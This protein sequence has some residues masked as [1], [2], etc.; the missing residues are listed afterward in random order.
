MSRKITT[1]S[2]ILCLLCMIL[3][4]IT[5][6]FNAKYITN[7]S[8]NAVQVHFP[9]NSVVGSDTYV[10]DNAD[11]GTSSSLWGSDDPANT[12][13][14]TLDTLENVEIK[15]MN[16]TNTTMKLTFV[17]TVQVIKG[18]PI[19]GSSKSFTITDTVTG[20]SASGDNS[21]I[22]E[23]GD[24]VIITL[25]GDDP[26]YYLAPDE[27]LHTYQLNGSWANQSKNGYYASLKVI[28]EPIAS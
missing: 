14:F 19:N 24:S 15:V 12:D 4:L 26:I 22:E 16:D 27:M 3:P 7:S 1:V 21:V 5:V 8:G 9:K 10:V 28:A 25:T 18:N 2:I 6:E 23:L 17:L 11:G 13:G 20:E